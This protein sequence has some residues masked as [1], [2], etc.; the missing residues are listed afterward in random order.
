MPTR[1]LPVRLTEQEQQQKGS[2]LAS[3][4]GEK[5]QLL[6]VGSRAMTAGE[7]QTTFPLSPPRPPQ[8]PAVAGVPADLV[9]AAATP[10]PAIRTEPVLDETERRAVRELV[11]PAAR[12]RLAAEGPPPEMDAAEVR[13][14][15]LELDD[16]PAAPGKPAEA[17]P[18]T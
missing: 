1:R 16:P 14:S 4:D 15:L 2:A 12:P 13:F 8:P 5:R 10:A 11:A 3:L 7:R 17:V 9:A 18:A 6:V